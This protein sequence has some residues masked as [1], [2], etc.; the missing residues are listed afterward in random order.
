MVHCQV[1]A[2]VLMWSQRRILLSWHNFKKHTS[3]YS[4]KDKILSLSLVIMQMLTFKISD[5]LEWNVSRGGLPGKSNWKWKCPFIRYS[6]GQVHQ[7]IINSDFLFFLT[8]LRLLPAPAVA[9]PGRSEETHWGGRFLGKRLTCL[10][11]GKYVL[12]PSGG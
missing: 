12:D 7:G 2:G 8:H 6:N 11:I 9:T 10:Q 3:F 4:L 5:Q 1:K